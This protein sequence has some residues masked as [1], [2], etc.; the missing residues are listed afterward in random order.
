MPCIY[1]KFYKK[2]NCQRCLN[3]TLE[4]FCLSKR[5]TGSQDVI[6]NQMNKVLFFNEF[7]LKEQKLFR[8]VTVYIDTKVP[9]EDYT[10]I[11]KPFY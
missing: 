1:V 2:G 4:F 6:E 11:E 10:T 5:T 3:N 9:L 8:T 7:K